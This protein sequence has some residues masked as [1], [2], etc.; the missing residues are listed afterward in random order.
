MPTK[1]V[2]E[3]KCDNAAFDEDRDAEVARLLRALADG[4]LG[5]GQV[6]YLPDLNGNIV[7]WAS[8]KKD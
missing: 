4:L 1:F 5:L 8:Y 3:I 6:Y 7:G 2:V